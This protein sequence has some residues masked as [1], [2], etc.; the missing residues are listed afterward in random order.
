MQWETAVKKFEQLTQPH[1]PTA[2]QNRIEDAVQNLENFRIT[3]LASLLERL[4]KQS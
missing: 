4:K 2:L 1:L 3:D